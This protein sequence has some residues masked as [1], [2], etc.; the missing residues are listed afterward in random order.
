MKNYVG[1]VIFV[2]GAAIGS[3]ATWYYAKK[4]YEQIA[5]EEIDSVKERF[6]IDN[7]KLIKSY[8]KDDPKPPFEAREV[9]DIAKE[10]LTVAEYAKKLSAQGYTNYSNSEEKEE[11]NTN[12]KVT[13]TPFVISPDEFG[14]LEDE[15][16]D[17]MNF[18]YYA[19]G[20]LADEEDE[21]VD[22]VEGT[23][24][25]DSL[26]HF[27]DYEDDSVHVRNN[28]LKVDYEILLS[29]REYSEILEEKPYLR[30]YDE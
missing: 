22:D 24:G 29:Q 27:G 16:Y 26:N 1:F 25:A 8:S 18:T 3:A 2:A 12:P 9:A 4:H 28:R 19:D 6:A 15:G 10:K 13:E 30:R 14:E 23:V 11:V 7:T 5:Q 17:K 20:V 21:I